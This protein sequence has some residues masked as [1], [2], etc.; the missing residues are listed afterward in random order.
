[1]LRYYTPKNAFDE[2]IKPAIV[3]GKLAIL[4]SDCNPFTSDKVNS[5]ARQLSMSTDSKEITDLASEYVLYGIDTAAGKPL[6]KVFH[7]KYLG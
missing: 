6:L 3:D 5:F 2:I 7:K 4:E 1:M